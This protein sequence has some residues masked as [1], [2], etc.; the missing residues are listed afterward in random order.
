MIKIILPTG[1][2]HKIKK[3]IR[4][5]LTFL[6]N[7]STLCKNLQ[8]PLQ[9]KNSFFGVQPSFLQLLFIRIPKKKKSETV[10][11]L[12]QDGKLVEIDKKLL[13][14]PGK[15]ISDIELQQWVKK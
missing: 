14:S 5:V 15:K 9:G 6:F 2:A 13:A 12:T 8:N 7:Q 1:I 11:M 3:N 4:V 10:K